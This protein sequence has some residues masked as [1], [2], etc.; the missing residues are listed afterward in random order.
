MRGVYGRVRRRSIPDLA[1]HPNRAAALRLLR[2][3]SGPLDE[4]RGARLLA[5]YGVARPREAT[6]A[7]PA[8]AAAAARRLGFPVAV[9]A[10]ADPGRGCKP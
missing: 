3:L 4:A 10:L 2:G 5:L 1:P 7:S 8:A 9:K 6:E